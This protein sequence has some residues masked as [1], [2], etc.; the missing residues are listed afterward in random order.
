MSNS[1]MKS[2]EYFLSLKEK[3]ERI[4][5]LLK[6][7]SQ[8][9]VKE[10]CTKNGKLHEGQYR[11]IMDSSPYATEVTT[12]RAGKTTGRAADHVET[13]LKY[14]NTNSL[15]ITLT[16]SNAK[17]IFFPIVNQINEKYGLLSTPNISDL[18]FEYPNGSK[19][20]LAGVNDQMAIHNFR[21]MKF[22][23]VTI[24]E[25]QSMRPYIKELIDEV[26][27]PALIDEKGRLRLSGTPGAIPAGYFYEIT[28]SKHWKHHFFTMF[29]NP[30]MEEPEKRLKMEL[31]RRGVT[32]DHPTIQREFFG[33]WVID[34]ESL[35]IFLNDSCYYSEL[36]KH[37]WEYVVSVD[38]GFEDSDAIA[39]IAFSETSPTAYLV[40]EIVKN[41]QGVTELAQQLEGVVRKY[42]PLKI[43]MDTGGLGK[44]IAEEIRRR[45]GL[46][47]EAAEKTRKYEYI[48]ILND[49]SRTGRFKVLKD[50]AFA[51]DAKLLEWE[52]DTEKQKKVISSK[53]H[54][55]IIDAVLYGLRE[56][57]H[58]MYEP[59]KT[60][61]EIYS[62]EWLEDQERE[63]VEQI[64]SQISQNKEDGEFWG[65]PFEG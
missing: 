56:S 63:H 9:D 43:V 13:A 49:A 61:P 48:E 15:Y 10:F 25:P 41:K 32:V 64:E 33:K 22:K 19:I 11:A 12:R 44:K 4:L 7:R 21:G 16:R 23:L 2:E 29:D 37:N 5:K 35:V 53:Y 59:K 55:D 65:D 36:P 27:A 40:E 20:Y 31:E 17:K 14:P 1:E 42:E 38:I 60:E 47:V 50:S 57:L 62:K 39:V 54:S 24:D 3:Q 8:F 46:P 28:Q 58:W 34:L 51:Q 30:F 45:Y 6:R 26:L 52:I 18:S